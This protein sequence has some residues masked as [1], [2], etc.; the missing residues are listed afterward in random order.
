[1]GQMEEPSGSNWVIITFVES[2]ILLVYSGVV[3]VLQNLGAG[4][5]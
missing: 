3:C 5:P 1:M 4:L 2:L